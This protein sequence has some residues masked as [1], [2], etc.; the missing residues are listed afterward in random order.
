MGLCYYIQ[1]HA[2]QV[3]CDSRI[4]GVYRIEDIHANETRALPWYVMSD[5]DMDLNLHERTSFR[6]Y[7]IRLIHNLFGGSSLSANSYQLQV[8]CHI[9]ACL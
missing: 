2:M 4:R 9:L 1:C 7:R 8:V 5:L 6:M 3:P